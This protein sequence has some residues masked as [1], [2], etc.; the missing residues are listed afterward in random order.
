MRVGGREGCSEGGREGCS[1]GGRV[2]RTAILTALLYQTVI[3]GVE[4]CSGCIVDTSRS[5]KLAPP[6]VSV[7]QAPNYTSKDSL[8]TRRYTEK[9][10]I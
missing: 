1:E 6:Q 10:Q 8:E 9:R 2:H 5:A 4:G 3:A 7:V